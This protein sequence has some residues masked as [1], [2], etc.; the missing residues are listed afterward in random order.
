MPASVYKLVFKDPD[1]KKLAP[2]TLEIGTYTTD[3]VM[4]VGSCVF[5]WFT[6]TLINYIFVATND[7]SVLL[8]YITTLAFG[9][10]QP[11]T[12]LDYL[13]PRAT[14]ITSSV[15]HSKRTKLAKDKVPFNWGPEYQ[16]AF[17]HLK[18]EIACAAILAYYNPKKQMVLQTDESIKGLGTCLLKDE[19]PVYFASKALIDTQKGY[20]AIELESL[21]VG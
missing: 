15:D 14:L 12:R 11:H 17:I 3:N 16:S 8:S 10:I 13:S 19:K 5:I 21:A 1:L 7:G 2:I 4:I 18:K 6:Q 9:L 20:D